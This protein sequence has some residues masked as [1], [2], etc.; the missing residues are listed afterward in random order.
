MRSEMLEG[1]RGLEMMGRRM[2]GRE[3]LQISSVEVSQIH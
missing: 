1:R 3:S 2:E